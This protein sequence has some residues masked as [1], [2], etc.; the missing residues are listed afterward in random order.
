MSA[1]CACIFANH[2]QQNLHPKVYTI[3]HNSKVVF[4]FAL[5]FA[6]P[7]LFIPSVYNIWEFAGIVFCILGVVSYVVF[8]F[9]LEK[10]SV[11]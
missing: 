1:A 2:S 9:R 3:L 8:S 10:V 6:F 4:G 5:Q 11:I 7:Q